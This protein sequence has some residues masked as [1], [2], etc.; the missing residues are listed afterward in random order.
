MKIFKIEYLVAIPG[1]EPDPQGYE[2][3]EL[4]VTPYRHLQQIS[5]ST[6]R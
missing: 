3:S 2:P 4:T 6:I 5:T 1:I